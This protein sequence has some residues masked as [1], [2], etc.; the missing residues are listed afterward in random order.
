M[1]RR[2]KRD[3]L[4]KGKYTRMAKAIAFLI[5]GMVIF[6][7]GFTLGVGMVLEAH[8]DRRVLDEG[9]RTTGVITNVEFS[10]GGRQKNTRN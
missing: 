9:V 1:A 5:A 7:G 10:T 6:F 4:A 3:R 8:D 2:S